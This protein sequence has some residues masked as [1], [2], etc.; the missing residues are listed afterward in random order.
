MRGM[1]SPAVNVLLT[2]MRLADRPRVFRCSS[3]KKATA[4]ITL[5]RIKILVSIH[6]TYLISLYRTLSLEEKG[7]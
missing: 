6:N 2:L 1:T 3:V 7:R 4:S 5:S